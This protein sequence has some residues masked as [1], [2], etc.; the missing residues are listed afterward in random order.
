MLVKCMEAVRLYIYINIVWSGVWEKP[1]IIQW[2][3]KWLRKNAQCNR[4]C[5]LTWLEW[6]SYYR[7]Q[8]S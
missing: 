1:V 6:K 2:G 8:D 3:L 5:R 4:Y 7:D